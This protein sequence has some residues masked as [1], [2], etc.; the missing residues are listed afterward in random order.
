MSLPKLNPAVAA[1]AENAR[2]FC[3]LIED[4]ASLDRYELAKRCLVVLPLLISQAS[5]LPDIG[6]LRTQPD[7][8]T[9]E[10]WKAIFEN[11]RTQLGDR[12]RYP[13]IFDPWQSEPAE[14]L[15]GSISDDLAGTWSDLKLGLLVLDAGSPKNA[16]AEW[17][18]SF[19]YHWGPNHAT[20]V[21]RP[22]LGIVLEY[23]E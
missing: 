6:K 9:H 7:E 23:E 18:Y 15:F 8:I 3:T 11:L 4:A 1:F 21:L 12:D 13:K 17:H 5:E 19:R 22:L 10:S 20:H 16:A 14:S 2:A